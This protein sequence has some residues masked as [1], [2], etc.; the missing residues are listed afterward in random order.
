MTFGCISAGN[1][2]KGQVLQACLC[3]SCG[4]AQT[5]LPKGNHA[6]VPYIQIQSPLPASLS[7]EMAKVELIVRCDDKAQPNEWAKMSWFLLKLNE[8]SL[9]PKA[10]AAKRLWNPFDA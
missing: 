3:S 1:N 8:R 6:F 4:S 5:G 9:H 7:G 10:P 2:Y